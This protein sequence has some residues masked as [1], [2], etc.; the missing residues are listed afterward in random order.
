MFSHLQIGSIGRNR[1]QTI[2][3][4]IDSVFAGAD[5]WPVVLCGQ[6]CF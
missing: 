1:E 4:K 5:S 2:E 6:P 3:K